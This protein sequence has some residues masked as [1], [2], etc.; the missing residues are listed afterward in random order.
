M[1]GRRTRNLLVKLVR[2][3]HTGAERLV[4]RLE[5]GERE[6]GAVAGEAGVAQGAARAQF[7]N[8]GVEGPPAHWLAVVGRYAPQLLSQVSGQCKILTGL[9][10]PGEQSMTADPGP[11]PTP[12][13]KPAPPAAGEKHTMSARHDIPSRAGSRVQQRSVC[14]ESGIQTSTRNKRSTESE[15]AR[16]LIPAPRHRHSTVA[17]TAIRASRPAPR[18]APVDVPTPR[19]PRQP[20]GKSVQLVQRHLLRPFGG[21]LP[22]SPHSKLHDSSNRPADNMP[23]FSHPKR[24]LESLHYA[25]GQERDTQTQPSEQLEGARKVE[26]LQAPVC[27][28]RQVSAQVSS[29]TQRSGR[30]TSGA[31]MQSSPATLGMPSVEPAPAS[32]EA[33]APPRQ[34]E[35]AWPSLPDEMDEDLLAGQAGTERWPT[36]PELSWDPGTRLS[37]GEALLAASEERRN[38]LRLQRRDLEQRGELWSA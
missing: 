10:K 1:L 3:L 35:S 33:V 36:L 19:P 38:R 18:K 34:A 11:S 8:R 14:S 4:L 20:S 27:A 5:A 17:E 7:V 31:L 9:S 12:G 22:P 6:T 26:H 2:A 32:G 23:V 29:Q 15:R 21:D 13:R 25:I 37:P 24:Q 16:P 30:S 28:T